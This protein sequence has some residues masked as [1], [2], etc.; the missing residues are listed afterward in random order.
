MSRA[1]ERSK[2][3]QGVRTTVTIYDCGTELHIMFDGIKYLTE[4]FKGEKCLATLDRIYAK[5][6]K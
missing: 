1:H 2:Y 6:Q 3:H 4:T 5:P